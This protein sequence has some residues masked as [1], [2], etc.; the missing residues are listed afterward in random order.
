MNEVRRADDGESCS[1][2]ATRAT[3]CIQ[4]SRPWNNA[5]QLSVDS[6]GGGM[7]KV[8]KFHSWL[9]EGGSIV[10]FDSSIRIKMQYSREW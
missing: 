10:I 9:W 1:I 6:L 3:E 4:Q 8:M 7:Q 2:L 5:R